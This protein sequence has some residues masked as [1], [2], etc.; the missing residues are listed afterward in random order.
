M[1]AEM[2]ATEFF[3][4]SPEQYTRVMAVRSFLVPYEL[5]EPPKTQAPMTN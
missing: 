3:N 1:K 5:A 2:L 4:P